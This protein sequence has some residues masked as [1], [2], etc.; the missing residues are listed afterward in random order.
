VLLLNGNPVGEDGARHLMAALGANETLQF[1]ALQ[2][3]NLSCGQA[4]VARVHGGYGLN[5]LDPRG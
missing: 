5:R 1:L 4:A 2:G 3:S